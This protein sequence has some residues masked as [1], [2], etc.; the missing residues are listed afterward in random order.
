MDESINTLNI[1]ASLLIK[2]FNGEISTEKL[3]S[4]SD[5]TDN[6]EPGIIARTKFLQAIVDIS[7]IENFAIPKNELDEL[8]TS[9][10]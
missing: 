4:I 10:N 5:R 2:D 1:V 7:S 6:Y 8:R 9:I 3:N